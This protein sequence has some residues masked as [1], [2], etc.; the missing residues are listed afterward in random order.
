MFTSDKIM[1]KAAKKQI[2]RGYRVFAPVFGQARIVIGFGDF[3]T[4]IAKITKFRC[5]IYFC[6]YGYLIRL[7]LKF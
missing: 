1:Q 6:N 2:F 7:K 4:T 3:I 5:L